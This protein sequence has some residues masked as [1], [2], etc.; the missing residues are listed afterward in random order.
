[1]IDREQ[2]ARQSEENLRAMEGFARLLSKPEGW[3]TPEEIRAFAA[4]C[5][6]SEKEALQTLLA[7]A[8]GWE[9]R[10]FIA[11]Y[12]SPALQALNPADT[13]NNP[14]LRTVHFPQARAGNWLLTRL[15][16]PPYAPFPCGPSQLLPDGRV[17]P[18][19][20]YFE[21]PF[22][23]PA[24]LENGR[25]WMTVTPNEIAT[26]KAPIERAHGRVAALGLGL[27]YF[28]FMAARKKEV[29]QVTVVERDPRV[30]ALFQRHL[31]PQFPCR[32]KIRLAQEDAFD[33][34]EKG[35]PGIDY[36]FADIWHD[37]G[38]GLPL[39][40]RLRRIEKSWLPLPV[41][42]WIENEML[43]LLRSLFIDDWL[44]QA[45]RLDRQLPDPPDFSLA[46]IRS[47]APLVQEIDIR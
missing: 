13:A 34:M 46:A 35:L 1:M 37:A 2:L 39:Y 25:E 3:Y 18:A 27:G 31:L 16:Y 45:G 19:L 23:Y 40:L 32:E 43:L 6:L 30:I 29:T 33:F 5:G 11:R 7:A 38:D 36:A 10:G 24:V 12:L 22:P 41:D 15:S 28:A 4:D 9:D 47:L 26:M 8:L 20:G 44:S 42:Y 14:Y 17:I 21:A